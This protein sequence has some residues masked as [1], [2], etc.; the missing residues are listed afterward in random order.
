MTPIRSVV[1]PL[2]L[3]TLVVAVAGASGCAWMRNKLG[4][5]DAYLRSPENRPLEVPPGLDTPPTQG[6]VAIPSLPAGAGPAGAPTAVPTADSAGVVAGIDAFTLADAVDSAWRRVGI[7]LGKIEGVTVDD[8][9]QLLNSYGVTYRG[10]AMLIRVEANGDGSR[11]VALGPDG[12][13]LTTDLLALL[14]ARL[15]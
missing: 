7:A 5:S 12:R 9:A 13:P 3:A 2:L 11:V 1:R 8:R 10:A 6:A 15:G 14:K 4:N